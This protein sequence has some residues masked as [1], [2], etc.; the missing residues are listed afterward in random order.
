MATKISYLMACL[1]GLGMIFLGIRFFIA[2]EL[3]TAGF[4]IQYNA[5]GDYSFHHIKGIRDIFSG[6]LLC[7]FVLMNQKKA[8]GL[9]L[10]AGTIIPVNDLQ[11]VLNKPYN[12]LLQG[13][14]HI[15]A[16]AVCAIF[17]CILLINSMAR[18]TRV[19]KID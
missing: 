3:A 10:L 6:I 15:I 13:M 1:L 14:P 16:I 9:T 11:I 4:G 17:G 12:G 18:G 19:R 7:G 5:G 8:V 2:P